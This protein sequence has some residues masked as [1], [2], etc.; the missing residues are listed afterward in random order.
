[1]PK[2]PQITAQGNA[3]ALQLPQSSGESFGSQA[4]E[5]LQ[6]LGHAFAYLDQKIQAQKDDLDFTLSR[7]AYDVELATQ[8]QNV[9]ADQSLATPAQKVVKLKEDRKS[10]V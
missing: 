5:G 10:V 7:N 3:A 6:R 2:L 9:L 8:Y 1:M 4:G